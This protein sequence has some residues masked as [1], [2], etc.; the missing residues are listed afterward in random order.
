MNKLRDH[1][2]LLLINGRK[3]EMNQKYPEFTKQ[4]IERANL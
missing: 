3:R 1:I 4:V 2:F